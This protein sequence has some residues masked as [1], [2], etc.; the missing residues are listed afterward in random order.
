MSNRSDLLATVVALANTFANSVSLGGDDFRANRPQIVQLRREIVARIADIAALAHTMDD[1]S[2][3]ET[4][5]RETSA[6][7]AAVAGHH[8][9]WPIVTIDLDDPSYQASIRNMRQAYRHFIALA[10]SI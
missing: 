6:M 8:A 4:L 5:A 2:L 7:R 10:K 9:A 1:A 3:S